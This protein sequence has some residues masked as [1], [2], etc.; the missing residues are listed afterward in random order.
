MDNVVNNLCAKIDDDW[1]RNEKALALTT[2]GTT[3]TTFITPDDPFPGPKK[4]TYAS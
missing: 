2:T 3:T 1:L 4:H